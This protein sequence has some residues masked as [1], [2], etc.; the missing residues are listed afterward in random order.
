[1]HRCIS[2]VALASFAAVSTMSAQPGGR[3][4]GQSELAARMLLAHTGELQLTDQQVVR[5]AAIARRAE[6][7]RQ[8]QR[9]AMDSL[10]LRFGPDRA[11]PMDSTARRQLR[12]QMRTRMTQL[13]EQRRVDQRD[14]LA[15]LTAD[16]QARAWEMVTSRRGIG[17]RGMRRGGGRHRGMDRG[18]GMRPGPMD[19]GLRR[20]AQPRREAPRPGV[21]RPAPPPADLG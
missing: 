1:M 7:R 11:A 19:R 6:S 20:D 12:E 21:R 4:P 18:R 3:G 10:R 15:V 9:S 5:L 13:A 16:Q 14:A 8:A 17:E 2:L